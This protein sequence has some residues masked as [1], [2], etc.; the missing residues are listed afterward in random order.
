MSHAKDLLDLLLSPT[1][2]KTLASERT[3]SPATLTAT[4]V[5]KPPS[6][7]SVQ[8]FNSQL[9]I[10][11]KDQALRNAADVFKSA[12]GSMERGRIKG[13]KYWV[14]ALK[15]RRGNWGLIPAPLP[16]GSA[17]GKGADK[18]SK[19]LLVSFGLE[20]CEYNFEHIFRNV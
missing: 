1:L 3:T 8:S 17:T 2:P 9:S 19:D 5:T 12:A 18:T 6:I 15:I 20:E 10:G 16:F 7:P 4:T 11:G 13:E 14:D